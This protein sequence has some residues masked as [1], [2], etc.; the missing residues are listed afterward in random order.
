VFPTLHAFLAVIRYGLP[1]QPK[2]SPKNYKLLLSL[3]VL[4]SIGLVG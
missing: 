1:A 3:L 2:F 4:A